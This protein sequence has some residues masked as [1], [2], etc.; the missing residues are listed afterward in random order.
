M[1]ATIT[2]I[3]AELAGV[4]E[5]APAGLTLWSDLYPVESLKEV[6]SALAAVCELEVEVSN[7]GRSRLT[8]TFREPPAAEAASAAIVGELLN[9][10]LIRTVRRLGS[11]GPP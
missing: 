10:V 4:A 6:A 2:R 8:I 3:L 11:F 1:T 7:P 9:G 5:G